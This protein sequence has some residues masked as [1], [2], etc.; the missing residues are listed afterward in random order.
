VAFQVER[1]FLAPNFICI[2]LE[3]EIHFS[4][5]LLQ[6]ARPNW[7]RYGLGWRVCALLSFGESSNAIAQTKGTKAAP[8]TVQ[9]QRPKAGFQAIG[10][11]FWG[12]TSGPQGGDV[13]ALATNTSGFVFAGTLGGGAFRSSDGAETWTAINNGLTATDVRALAINTSDDLFAGTFGGVFRSTDNGDTWA[14]VNNGLDYPFV[15][16]LAINS[17]GDVFAGTFE[18]G[19]VYRSTDNGESWALVNNG[20]TNTCVYALAINTSGDIFA[21]T[22][23]SGIFRS[24]DNGG[25]WVAINSGLIN[26]FVTSLTINANGD[27]FAGGDSIAGGGIFRSTNNGDSWELVINGLNTSNNVDALIVTSS[28]EIFAGIYGDGVFRSTNNGDNWTQ[29]N[30]GLTAT[31]VLSFTTDAC[32]GQM[33]WTWKRNGTSRRP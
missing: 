25:S 27:I 1:W 15:I 32:R 3:K 10:Q 7:C 16:S 6:L 17:N 20:L 24:T 14:S 2:I 9:G 18:G 4:I 19:G 11:N 26:P 12:S 13:L 31:F 8:S 33:S 21:P 5:R 28:G 22:W 29:V 30:N 23:G